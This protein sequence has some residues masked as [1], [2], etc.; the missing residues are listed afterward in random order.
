MRAALSPRAVMAR[1]PLLALL[2][3]LALPVRADPL[4][5][6]SQ[7]L[8]WTGALA[9]LEQA[10]PLALLVLKDEQARLAR[11]PSQSLSPQRQRELLQRFEARSLQ[12]A[13]IARIATQLPA[14]TLAQAQTALQQPLAKRVRFFERALTQPQVEQ[15]WQQWREQTPPAAAARL[16]QLRAI[17]AAARDSQLTAQLQTSIERAVQR[18]FGIADD[19]LQAEATGER[20]QHLQPFTEQ[21]LLYAYRYLRDD[22][23]RQY[24]QL[25]QDPALQQ[26]FDQI[27]AGVA[28]VIAN[29]A[30]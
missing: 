29:A 10:R 18:Q 7:L 24:E 23:L 9:L 17:D 13:L 21:Y 3:V 1:L 27:D 14:E 20:M 15:E 4:A 8:E 30:N 5:Q 25:L 28:E 6:T 19:T 2:C 26:L 22:E 16:Q 12:Q 11:T